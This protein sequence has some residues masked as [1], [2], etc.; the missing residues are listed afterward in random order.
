[1]VN[2][3]RHQFHLDENAAFPAVEAVR[4]SFKLQIRNPKLHPRP[5]SVS[6][7]ATDNSFLGEGAAEHIRS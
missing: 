6:E 7:V 2:P 1:M 5:I 4:E 3:Q